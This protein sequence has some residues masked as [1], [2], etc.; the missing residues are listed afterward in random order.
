[1]KWNKTEL[2]RM[3]CRKLLTLLL[4]SVHYSF[5]FLT[6][7]HALHQTHIPRDG[8]QHQRRAVYGSSGHFNLII[9]HSGA[10]RAAPLCSSN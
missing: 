6:P 2:S 10:A 9:D 4:I 1:M 8:R 5:L 3:K 7:L